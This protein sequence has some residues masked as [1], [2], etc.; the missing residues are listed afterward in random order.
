MRVIRARWIV[1]LLVA[2]LVAASCGGDDAAPETSG[3]D[4]DPNGTI[5][6]GADLTTGQGISFDPL[7]RDP[8]YFPYLM[9]I[10][11]TLLRLNPDGTTSPA[12]ADSVNILDPK[13]LEVV[14][15]AG[16][17]FSDGTPLDT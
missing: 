15:R 5:K 1:V 17:V 6:I 8:S 14:L 13:T 10:Y 2:L 11:D 3:G 16:V 12:L 9:P 4:Y 7:L